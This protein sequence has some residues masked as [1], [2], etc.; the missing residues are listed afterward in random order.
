MRRNDSHVRDVLQHV[1]SALSVSDPRIAEFEQSDDDDGV[2]RLIE[3]LLAD[4]T[5]D[6]AISHLALSLFPL[7]PTPSLV[8]QVVEVL[9]G[10][11]GLSLM[12]GREL[13][14]LADPAVFPALE[15]ILLDSTVATECRVGVTAALADLQDRRVTPLLVRA[16]REGA[17]EPVVASHVALTLGYVQLRARSKDCAKDLCALL[18]SEHPDVRFAAVSALGNMWAFDAVSEIEALGGDQGVTTSRQSVG[19]R[20]KHV[21]DLL[22]RHMPKSDREGNPPRG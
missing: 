18:G 4:R 12:A 3:A 6:L 11:P 8:A 22:R 15:T 9:R 2:S 10:Q 21:S 14:R 13:G 5:L 16:L 20:A 7:F 19:Q 1:L 17:H